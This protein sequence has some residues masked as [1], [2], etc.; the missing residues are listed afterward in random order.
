MFKHIIDASKL[1]YDTSQ[2]KVVVKEPKAQ[3]EI[4]GMKVDLSIKGVELQVPRW[5]A[6]K[7]VE[8]GV[9]EAKLADELSLKDLHGILWRE[10][11]EINLTEIDPNFYHKLRKQLKKL[12]SESIKNPTPELLDTLRKFE[13]TARDIVSCRIQKIVQAALSES[14]PPEVLEVMTIEERALLAEISE[15]IEEWKRNVLEGEGE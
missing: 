4:G 10:S 11:R 15:L 1:I 5:A 3:V 12:R 9:V 2:V 6:E 7:L 13:S 14:L 8:L